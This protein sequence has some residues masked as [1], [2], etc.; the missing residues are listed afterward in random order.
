MRTVTRFASTRPSRRLAALVASLAL[1]AAGCGGDGVRPGGGSALIEGA[2]TVTGVAGIVLWDLSPAGTY[3]FPKGSPKD[4]PIVQDTA[5]VE[6]FRQGITAW[7]DTVLTE[8]NSGS[9]A[10]IAASG[11]DVTS[12]AAAHGTGAGTPPTKQIVTANYLIE[13]GYLG[14]PGWATVRVEMTVVD[15]ADQSVPPTIRVDTFVFAE[16]AAG[17]ELIAYEAA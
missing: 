12:F 4:A 7:L 2:Q 17:P 14:A 11:L 6:A 13:I 5:A 8:S 9:T 15:L 16:G 1:L 3:V 10:T